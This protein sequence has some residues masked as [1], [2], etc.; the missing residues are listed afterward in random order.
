[1]LRTAI[2]HKSST[3][4]GTSINMVTQTESGR[5]LTA[6][7]S[8]ES[9]ERG[10]RTPGPDFSGHGISSAAAVGSPTLGECEKIAYFIVFFASFRQPKFCQNGICQKPVKIQSPSWSGRV[11][12][13]CQ[14]VLPMPRRSR[15]DFKLKRPFRVESVYRIVSMRIACYCF[16]RRTKFLNLERSIHW[17][18]QWLSPTQVAGAFLLERSARSTGQQHPTTSRKCESINRGGDRTP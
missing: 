6:T 15:P 10:I 9:G 18:R 12:H 8:Y 3:R 14:M 17:G 11:R 4:G 1:M 7:S 5:R 13:F 16:P 2:Q